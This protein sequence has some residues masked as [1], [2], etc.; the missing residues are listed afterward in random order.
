ML[1][2]DRVDMKTWVA[3]YFV[4]GKRSTRYFLCAEVSKLEAILRC[5]FTTVKH[6]NAAKVAWRLAQCRKSLQGISVLQ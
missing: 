5:K 4:S 2:A 1:T 3:V 6:R